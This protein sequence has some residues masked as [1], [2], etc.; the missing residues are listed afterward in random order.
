MES[1]FY[2][3]FKFALGA[4]AAGLIFVAAVLAVLAIGWVGLSWWER[5]GYQPRY[6]PRSPLENPPPRKP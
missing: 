4:M 5:Q 3:G 6:H 1:A 2:L